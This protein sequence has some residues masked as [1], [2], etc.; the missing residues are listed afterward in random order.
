[1]TL[2]SPQHP[3]FLRR[4]QKRLP[5]LVRSG[6]SFNRGNY[7]GIGLA[8]NSACAAPAS[9][10]LGGNFCRTDKKRLSSAGFDRNGSVELVHGAY[11]PS[12]GGM[13]KGLAE[14]RGR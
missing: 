5:R 1:M 7:Y 8:I 13:R 3:G 12:M 14:G 2:P 9:H 11:S 4:Q 10:L 6:L